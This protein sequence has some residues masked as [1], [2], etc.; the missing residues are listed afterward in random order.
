[1]APYTD[2]MAFSKRQ[3]Q[4]I[5]VF[6][7]VPPIDRV[8]SNKDPVPLNDLLEHVTEYYDLNKPSAEKQLVDAWHEIFGGLSE[9]CYPV[10]LKDSRILIIA[11]GNPTLRA[12]IIFQKKEI[13]KKINA[14][15]SCEGIRELVIRA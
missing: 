15:K 2:F 11:V 1:M 3:E 8:F 9:R 13:L 7:G 10:K 14:I 5:S 12:E 4:L 6:L